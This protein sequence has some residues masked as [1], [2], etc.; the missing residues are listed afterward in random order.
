MD[1]IRL[2]QYLMDN[3]FELKSIHIVWHPVKNEEDTE[4]KFWGFYAFISAIDKESG[5]MDSCNIEP[6]YF[7]SDRMLSFGYECDDLYLSRGI[8]SEPDLYTVLV[9]KYARYGD[10]IAKCGEIENKSVDTMQ[11]S[12]SRLSLLICFPD[13]KN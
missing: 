6:Q 8:S 9:W 4:I 3:N 10:V 1:T 5:E 11:Y 12:S 2:S 7:T 13:W